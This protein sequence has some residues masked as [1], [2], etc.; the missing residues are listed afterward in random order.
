MKAEIPVQD[1]EQVRE[2]RTQRERQQQKLKESKEDSNSILD[3]GAAQQQQAAAAAG[4]NRPPVE[5]VK[6][7]KSIKVAG[8]NDRVNVRYSDGSVKKNVKF[9]TVEDD[10]K[11]NRCVIL[12]D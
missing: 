1:P 10:L 6:P 4:R 8:R 7:A 5:P 11:N 12:D 2:A 3:R 9:K